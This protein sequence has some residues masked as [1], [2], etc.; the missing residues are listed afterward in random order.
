MAQRQA[1]LVAEIGSGLAMGQHSQFFRINGYGRQPRS[2]DPSWATIDHIAAEAGRLPS[3]ARHVAAPKPPLLLHG[4]SPA[5]VAGRATEVAERAR[6]SAGRKLR[7][8]GRVLFAAVASYPVPCSELETANAWSDYLA[9]RQRVVDFLLAWLG[10]LAVSIVEHRDES[11]PHVHALIVPRLAADRQLDLFWH[12]GYAARKQAQSAGLAHGEQEKAYRQGLRDCLDQY[13]AAV[14]AFSD[15]ARVGARRTRL[16]RREALAQK[17]AQ[18]ALLRAHQQARSALTATSAHLGPTHSP[19][20]GAI[21][22]MEVLDAGFAEAL[23]ILQRYRPE[24]VPGRTGPADAAM[25]HDIEQASEHSQMSG[26]LAQEPFDRANDERPADDQEHWPG[27][28]EATDT[29][30][31]DD[32]DPELEVPDLDY[33]DDPSFDDYSVIDPEEDLDSDPD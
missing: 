8:D 12:Q 10:V 28:V 32:P 31:E 18:D 11:H 1:G 17:A 6:D 2:G 25:H 24:W 7:A 16:R 22:A 26:L 13:H 19:A 23:A 14:S 21:V 33:D 5:N 20:M 3:A 30:F 15:H 9:W 29:D 27:N 4:I